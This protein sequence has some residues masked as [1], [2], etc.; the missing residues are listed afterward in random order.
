MLSNYTERTL[1]IAY[2]NYNMKCLI[3]KVNSITNI[4]KTIVVSE[5]YAVYGNIVLLPSS[6]N[7]NKKSEWKII[8]VIEE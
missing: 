4:T 3:K 7:S 2:L 1:A 5:K 8:T 6:S